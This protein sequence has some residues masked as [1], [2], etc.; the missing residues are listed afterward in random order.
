M[1]T[2]SAPPPSADALRNAVRNGGKKEIVR[3]HMR[4]LIDKMLARY[5]SEFVVCRELIQNAD[6]V[7]ATWF[8]FEITCRTCNDFR[9][10][11][12]DTSE[13]DF[14]NSC[15]TEICATNNGREFTETDWKRVTA[16]AEGN[17]DVDSVG[18][19]GVGFFSVFSLCE[20]PIIISGKKFMEFTWQD[21]R[22]LKTYLRELSTKKQ[23]QS[24]SICLTLNKKYI[25]LN[26]PT[27][28]HVEI[29][30]GNHRLP[31][32]ETTNETFLTLN[33]SDLKSYFTK[34]L[35][36]TKYINEFVIKIN[37]TIVF[38]IQKTKICK[39][40]PMSIVNFDVKKSMNNMLRFE[41]LSQNEQTFAITN[42]PCITLNHIS[43]KASVVV[44][45]EFQQKIRQILKK[46]LPSTIHIELLYAPNSIIKQ[47][48]Q[49]QLARNNDNNARIFN[50]IIP[51][52]FHEEKTTPAGYIFIGLGT[53]QSTGIG[54]HVF[55]HFIPTIEREN[56]DFQDPYILQWNR[57]LLLSAGQIARYVYDQFM[58]NNTSIITKQEALLSISSFQFQPSVPNNKIG[59]TIQSGFFDDTKLFVRVLKSTDNPG[60]HIF[61]SKN[62]YLSSS[63]HMDSF[64]RVP[65]IPFEL[66]QTHFFTILR[67]RGLINNADYQFIE[68]KLSESSSILI[69]NE[70]IQ[71]VH[72][73]ST[74]KITNEW[75]QRILS[76]V[77]FRETIR[78]DIIIM[79][80]FKFYDPFNVPSVLK[81]PQSILPA[82][83]AIHFSGEELQ[84]RLYLTPWSLTELTDYYLHA[85]QRYIF[86]LPKANVQLLSLF[87]KQLYQFQE[88]EWNKILL[89]LSGI[90]CIQTTRGMKIPSESYI[91]SKT[92]S[93]Y[94]IPIIK[95]N[96]TEEDIN[97][98]E[99][100]YSS[101][102]SLDAF[103]SIEFLKR[104][105]CRTFHL[106][107]FVESQSLSSNETIEILIQKL[108]QE[109]KNM[110]DADF[111]ALKQK[112][113]LQGTAHDST[114]KINRQ[115]VPQELYF[116]SVA[117]ELNWPTLLVIDWPD[118]KS[119]SQQYL[120]LKQLGVREVPD[121][122]LLIDR[123]SQE[124]NAKSSNEKKNQ[125]KYQLP[126]ALSYFIKYFQQHYSSLWT[127]AH[128]N[129]LFLPSRS[130]TTITNDDDDNNNNHR[131]NE[132]ILSK[133][134][135]LFQGIVSHD[136]SLNIFI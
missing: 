115:C 27:T 17:T 21:N 125:H 56:L 98:S 109:R 33:L 61:L 95:F 50:S 37:D 128:I 118:I 9:R 107:S 89:T 24:T 52:K 101:H 39:T 32:E 68:Q 59:N 119:T 54:M 57:E 88:S 15:I 14:H 25:L 126:K 60:L 64:L 120:F 92:L 43:V 75:S 78:S 127:T 48:Q 46:N 82:S 100:N 35:S 90:K 42:G 134:H 74:S 79:K 70:F 19:F 47:Q 11:S 104:L 55:S 10:Q 112:R 83:I 114:G 72:Y 123:I 87:S 91:P 22:I 8:H 94:D 136:M 20:E 18:Q 12:S 31:N 73:L 34:V 53:Q 77:R 76:V 80:N 49:I 3:T 110:T 62:S 5:S 102:N 6:D 129:Q 58:I 69:L 65:L 4:N 28:E 40:M 85:D 105:G 2:S 122:S 117:I 16:I 44:N 113:W 103:I 132:V 121:L 71:L 23:S 131:N 30:T 135:Q 106:G 63:E 124:H 51:L 116:P 66:S 1:A 38:E 81:L 29:L 7:G 36:F 13:I 26:H 130:P 99:N 133:A 67:E 111:S 96:T 41:S 84:S 93:S 45:T 108:M 86:L 97:D